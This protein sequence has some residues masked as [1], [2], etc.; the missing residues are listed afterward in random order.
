MGRSTFSRARNRFLKELVRE[1]REARMLIAAGF[2]GWSVS[3]SVSAGIFWFH[4][5]PKERKEAFK[6][7]EARVCAK[8]DFERNRI[9]EEAYLRGI[10]DQ[11]EGRA[12]VVGIE[13]A[14]RY[15]IRMP[16]GVVVNVPANPPVQ[17]AEPEADASED[18]LRLAASP[19]GF[20]PAQ[21]WR[22]ATI[23][24]CLAA[25]RAG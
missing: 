3:M 21:S 24:S 1:T 20:V 23:G 15:L 5:L 9:T 14:T 18:D 22:S 25:F 10:V 16:D 13:R 4:V 6:R 7:A 8:A 2:V 11:A 19:F 17:P 12:S